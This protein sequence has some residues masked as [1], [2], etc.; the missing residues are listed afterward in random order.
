MS[1][2][3]RSAERETSETDATS[4]V[5]RAPRLIRWKAVQ[6]ATPDRLQEQDARKLELSIAK[7]GPSVRGLATAVILAG[8]VLALGSG[9]SL[10]WPS[11]NET[12]SS[13][14]RAD[15][16][17]ASLD[18]DAFAAAVLRLNGDI[19][20]APAT[21][22][23]NAITKFGDEARSVFGPIPHLACGGSETKIIPVEVDGNIV[24]LRPNIGKAGHPLEFEHR[25]A[26]GNIIK[27]TRSIPRCDK[28]SLAGKVTYCGL[29][30]R[31]NRVVDGNVE[32]L[33]LC[34]KSNASLEVESD[35]YWLRSNP[36][37]ALLGAIGFNHATGELVFFDGR[38]DRSEFDWSKPFVP[39][40]GDSYSD[41]A[42][43]AAAEQLYDP[44]F[45]VQCSACHDNKNAYVITPHIAMARLGYGE[46]DPRAAS[47]SLGDYLP[48]MARRE[49]APF[50]II[51]SDYTLRYSVEIER[52][53]TVRDPTGNCTGCHTLTTQLTGQRFAADAVD[54]EPWISKPS[55][56][57]SVG[58]KYE[59][60]ILAEIDAHRTDWARRGGAGKIH[61]WMAPGAGNNLS[62]ETEAMSVADWGALS[63]CLWGA[64]GAEC[65]YRPLY[66]L[67]PAPGPGPQGD[68]YGP[69]DLSTAVLTLPAGETGAD[70]MLRAAWRYLNAYGNVPQRDDVRFDL[71]IRETMVPPDGRIP[72]A[73]DY[74]SVEE[75]ISATRELADGNVAL[76]SSTVVIRNASYLGH[77][78]FTDPAASIRPREFRIDLPVS[79]NQRYL[80]RLLP[81]RFCF[82]QSQEMYSDANYVSYTDFLC[83]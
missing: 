1:D 26:S 24:D 33:F 59:R 37:F 14:G 12:T 48:E 6:G 38:K 81:K 61:P 39:P 42:G 55:W 28:P 83:N 77:S 27:W 68:G 63:T 4:S 75:T 64:G 56:I 20:W 16:K 15:N 22:S 18:L 41:G 40:G 52:A 9:S 34:R 19:F 8:A 46:E 72:S 29:S 79:C 17:A 10:P 76:S 25:D 82:D 43:R 74:P 11:R 73:S 30:S 57:Q 35:P 78:R 60:H 65:G 5:D 49:D 36:K 32:W 80:V 66:T 44:T 45:R 47:F 3:A 58:L 67:C 54:L 50:R 23:E 71:A 69:E 31:L 51:G 53:R 21:A 13:F 62:A 70:G 2:Q 7:R